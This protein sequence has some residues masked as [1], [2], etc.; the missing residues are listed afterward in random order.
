MTE[1]DFTTGNGTNSDGTTAPVNNDGSAQQSTQIHNMTV[2][3]PADPA[4]DHAIE[5]FHDEEQSVMKNTAADPTAPQLHVDTGD[6]TPGHGKHMDQAIDQINLELKEKAVS[7]TAAT[8]GY[9]YINI[10]HTPINPDMFNLLEDEVMSTHLVLPFFKTGKKV[11]VAVADPK[12][13]EVEM[14]LQGMRDKGLLLNVNMASDTGIRKVLAGYLAKGAK[15]TVEVKNT[16]V[17]EAKLKAYEEEIKHLSEEG[18]AKLDE[19]PAEESVNFLC[20]GAIKTGASDMH[21]QPEE[22]H[23]ELR[24]RIDGMMQHI[25]QLNSKTYANILNQIKYKSKMKLN[26]TNEPQDGRFYFVV[27]EQKIDVRVSL[28]PTEFGETVVMRLLDARKGF[29][30]LSELGFSDFNHH[31]LERLCELSV[32]LVLVTGPT[33]SGKTTTLYAMLDRLNKPEVK[34]ITLENPI[35]YHLKGISQSQTNEKRGYNFASG[36]KSILRQDPNVVMIG[37]IRDLDT[38]TTTCQAALTGHLVLSTLHTNSAVE[39]IP[40]LLNIGVPEFMLAPTLKGIVAQRLVR[41]LCECKKERPIKDNEKELFGKKVAEF[42]EKNPGLELSVPTTLMSPQGCTKCSGDGYKGQTQIA[43]ILVIDE[44]LHDM[45]LNRVSDT[46]ISRRAVEKGMMTMEDDGI[47]KVLQGVTTL[48]EI[49][50]VT[51][52]G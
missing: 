52:R 29:L 12:S 45:I 16:D 23:C 28:I 39:S 10:T 40:R 36:L 37:E 34:I 2:E 15:K 3:I 24:F 20:V 13:S 14:V 9:P 43:E 46:E 32:G 22:D 49:F 26:I 51:N 17:D 6:S 5:E 4:I 30:S 44:E 42:N 35:E 27:N 33:G 38:A 50:R 41:T 31:I 18:S 11:R 1:Q 8:L 19:M 7:E 48:E 47:L 25:M 21:F